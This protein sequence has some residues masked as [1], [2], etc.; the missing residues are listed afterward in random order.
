MS[1]LRVPDVR[2]VSPWWMR[3]TAQQ[4]GLTEGRIAEAFHVVHTA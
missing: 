4:F 2:P 3:H 1:L